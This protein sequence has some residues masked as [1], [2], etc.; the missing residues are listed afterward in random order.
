MLRRASTSR[1]T[2]RN[3]TQWQLGAE[4]GY[5]KRRHDRQERPTQGKRVHGLRTLGV[6]GPPIA[7]GHAPNGHY[8]RS[9]VN[10]VRV[11]YMHSPARVETRASRL[12]TPHLHQCRIDPPAVVVF[13]RMS[14]GLS[15]TATGF[16]IARNWPG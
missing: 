1:L 7:A 4:G 16:S 2:E 11:W 10:R 3:A 5:E 8:G 9:L 15:V 6:F 13:V 12:R 14:S